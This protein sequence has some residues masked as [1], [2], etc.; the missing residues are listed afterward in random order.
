MAFEQLFTPLT[1]RR[2]TIRNRIFST[3]HMTNLVTGHSPNADLA[4]YHEARAAGGAGLIIMESARVHASSLSDQPALNAGHDDCIPG[5]AAVATAVQGHGAAVFGQLGHAGRVTAA[6]KRGRRLVTYAPSSVPD[7]RFHNMP[8]AMP[9]AMIE[10]LV[11]AFGRAG[12]RYR[13]AGLDGA[14]LMASHGLLIA[15]FLNPSVNR[16]EDRYG[17]SA[18]NRLRFAQE[19]LAAVRAELGDDKVLGLRISADEIEQGGLDPDAVIAICRALEA[20]TSLDYVNVIA[21]SMSGLAG[22]VHVVPPMQI[23]HGYVAPM[24]AALKAGGVTLPV[25]VAGRINQPQM[26]EAILASGQA[27]M[28]GMTRAMIA[29]PE[30]ARKAESG[31]LDDIRAC[32][33]CNQACIGHM[34]MGVGISCIQHPETGRERLYGKRPPADPAKRV[35]VAGG[36]PAGMKAAAVA[37]ER[38]HRVLLC[39][40][41]RQLGGQ[42]LLAQSLP[43]RAEFGGLAT[44]LQN[45]MARAGVEVRLN[46]RIDRAL[47]EREAPDAVILATGA[48]P[49]RPSIEGEEEAQVVDAWQLLRGEANPGQRVL[50]ADW[51]CDWVGLGL[52]EKLAL[53]GCHVR[54]AVNGTCAGQELQMYL[55]DL[56]AGRLH[57]LGVEVIPY[58]QLYG[59]DAD[60]AYLLHSASQE[61]I[62]CEDVDT[63]VLALGHQPVVALEEELAGLAIPLHLAGDCLAPR[64]AEEAVFEGLEAGLAV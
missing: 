39:E 19:T 29:D 3:G 20:T 10:E 36:G 22:S 56:W 32:I 25:F 44:N 52:A 61:P 41:G 51:R 4:A 63:V 42:V 16:R 37:A 48:R 31:R 28:C 64:S 62:L 18:E 27:D 53:D 5:F 58:A 8:R 60:T 49:H 9:L 38:G 45:E 23:E 6:L 14:E 2:L 50:I 15:Q 40:A 12:R 24:A 43:G 46:C 13:E 11:E 34:Q 1:L 55:R 47:V 7:D 57:K 33:G 59:A 26:A 17:G 21:G 54:L 30:M 35:L